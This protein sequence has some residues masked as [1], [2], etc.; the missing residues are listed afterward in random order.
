[1]NHQ[2]LFL[3]PGQ[4]REKL[5]TSALTGCVV[6]SPYGSL[7]V[8]GMNGYIRALAFLDKVPLDQPIYRLPFEG[9]ESWK[10]VVSDS[11]KEKPQKLMLVGTTFQHQVWGELLKIPKGT[12]KNYQDIAKALGGGNK[13]RPVGTAVGAN[14]ISWIVPCH[15]VLPKSGGIGQYHWGPEIK[16]KL[17]K[18]EGY[19]S[20]AKP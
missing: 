1:M 10:T 4:F 18:D 14:P 19:V 7:A 16:R 3:S 6:S 12:V 20:K 11:Q 2:V 5:K 13:S 9:D 8:R 17:L 15:R